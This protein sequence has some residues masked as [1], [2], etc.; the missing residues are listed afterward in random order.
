VLD[1]GFQLYRASMPRVLPLCALLSACDIPAAVYSMRLTARVQNS[2]DTSQILG[3]MR[4]FFSDPLYWA[5]VSVA[6]LLKVW[7]FAALTLQMNAIAR[8]AE[9]KTR[10]A[11]LQAL[12]LMASLALLSILYVLI[13]AA[14]MVLLIPSIVFAVSLLFVLLMV[15]FESKGP[16]TALAASHRLVW[17]CWWRT[18]AILTVGAII[19]IVMYSAVGLLI[20]VLTPLLGAGES[21]ILDITS[22]VLVTAGA[23][24]VMSPLYVALLLTIYWDLKLR[25]QG[26][27]LAERVEA[28]SAGA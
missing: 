28:L 7:L 2:V 8:D 11:V 23:T 14:G 20:G 25:K 3:F 16:F 5:L 10:D 18:S 19:A 1:V 9:L 13:V 4:E 27:D 22:T 26:G 17:G 6:W 15:L 21:P 24:M 12:R